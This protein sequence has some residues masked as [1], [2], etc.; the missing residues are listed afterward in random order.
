MEIR[1]QKLLAQAGVAS[2]RKAEEIIAARRVAVNGVI[3]AEAGAKA[4]PTDE[5]TVDG[6]RISRPPTVKTYIALHKPEGVVTTASEQFGRACVMDFVPHEV[7]LFPVGRLDFDTSGLLFLTNDGDWANALMHPSRGVEKTYRATL[8]GVP[9][10]AALQ[11]FRDGILIENR[12]TAPAKIKNLR[13]NIFEIKIH[14]GR[15][16]QIRK[17]CDALGYPVLSLMR[18]AIGEV[19]LGDLPSGEWRNLSANELNVLNFA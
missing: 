18:V 11:K 10:A 17:M 7:R 12:K 8:R 14:E 9:D 2:R 16:R 15:N 3:V 19:M 1:L 4:S 6:V 5:I 13:K